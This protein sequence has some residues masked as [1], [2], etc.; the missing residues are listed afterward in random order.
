[1]STVALAELAR[2]PRAQALRPQAAVGSG[3]HRSACRA[4][5]VPGV[6]S[7]LVLTSPAVAP[8]TRANYYMSS[9]ATTSASHPA[10]RRPEVDLLASCTVR[11]R[12]CATSEWCRYPTGQR[13]PAATARLPAK[14]VQGPSCGRQAAV[15]MWTK[16]VDLA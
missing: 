11:R 9:D 8:V 4:Y 13:L 6:W 10:R 1:V 3:L 2:C 12:S 14:C 15:S 16:R 7:S 5:R